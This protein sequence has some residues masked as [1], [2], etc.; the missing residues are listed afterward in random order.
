[1]YFAF[2]TVPRPVCPTPS[3]LA[4]LRVP[5]GFLY[6]I[7]LICLDHLDDRSSPLTY[8]IAVGRGGLLVRSRLQG[9]RFQVR[10]PIPLKIRRVC[11][12][13]HVKSYVE[14]QTSS[15]GVVHTTHVH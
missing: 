7:K 8:S 2:S 15:T 14:G 5:V 12:L 9:E 1:M 13:L 10:N 11:D 6:P 3:R 4:Y